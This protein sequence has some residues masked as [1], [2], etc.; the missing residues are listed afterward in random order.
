MSLE[1]TTPIGEIQQYIEEQLALKVAQL[2]NSLSYIGEGALRIA[3][4]KGSYTDRTGNLRNS[5]GYVIA[6]DGQIT[7]RAGFKSKNEDGAAFAEELA[8]TTDGKAVLVVC[9][10]MNYATYVSRRG[11]DVLDSAELEAKALADKLLKL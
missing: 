10:G 1:V 2:I 11:Y 6:V 4:E 7:A 3:R 8:R 5:T 9:A